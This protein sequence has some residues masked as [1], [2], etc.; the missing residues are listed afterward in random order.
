MKNKD[1]LIV[2]ILYKQ[3]IGQSISFNSIKNISKDYSIFYYNNSPD[4]DKINYRF[5]TA[6]DIYIHDSSNPGLSYAYNQAARFA[7]EKSFKWLLLLDQDTLLPE[8]ILE[9]YQ[10]LINSRSE[11]KLFASCVKLKMSDYYISPGIKRI[12]RAV[13]NGVK[14][15]GLLSL[16]DYTAINSG[17][18]INV[19]SFLEC[20]G[21]NE[22]V[23]LDFSDFQFFK[24]FSRFNK[25]FF[26]VDSTLEQEL[27]NDE[28]NLTKLVNR[29][30]MYCYCARNC[31]DDCI[32]DLVAYFI[33]VFGRATKLSLRRK[34][35]IF[36]KIV[37]FYYILKRKP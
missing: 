26:V 27:S 13:S 18:L 7:S 34:N 16:K 22:K 28:K 33:I 24:R 17:L 12:K 35:F 1:I 19:A 2:I 20:G 8:N 10:G 37:L 6:N 5:L 29:F 32:S 4:D 3:T 11:I 21:Y 25:Y 14:I 36:Y 23:P 31:T 9:L 15:S 30:K